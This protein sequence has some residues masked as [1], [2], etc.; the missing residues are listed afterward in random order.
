MIILYLSHAYDTDNG[1]VALNETQW[2]QVYDIFE[3]INDRCPDLQG[4]ITSMTMNGLIGNGKGCVLIVTE[5]DVDRVSSSIYRASTQLNAD[6]NHWS[7]SDSITQMVDDQLS[8]L[9][10]HRVLIDPSNSNSRTGFLVAQWILSLSN[11]Y[12][13]VYFS[14]EDMALRW[15]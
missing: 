5:A 12:D 8:Y 4:D 15:A 9:A 6:V 7:D 2:G 1:Y 14:I 3:G 10:S 13:N 11:L